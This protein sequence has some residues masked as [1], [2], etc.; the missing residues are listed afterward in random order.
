MD[1]KTLNYR[2]LQNLKRTRTD[3]EIN[4]GKSKSSG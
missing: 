1:H 2:K 4:W 3:K